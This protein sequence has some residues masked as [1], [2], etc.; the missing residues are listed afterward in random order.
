MR[1]PPKPVGAR[2]A[3]RCCVP[4][5]VFL[6][7][8]RIWSSA[9]GFLRDGFAAAWAVGLSRHDGGRRMRRPPSCLDKPTAHAAA[10][11]SLRK[12]SAEDQILARRRNTQAGTQHLTAGRAPTGLGG[13]RMRR[14]YSV[15]VSKP[16]LARNH[17]TTPS[18]QCRGQLTSHMS[19]PLRT[20]PVRVPPAHRPHARPRDARG[21]EAQLEQQSFP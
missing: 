11:P 1:R 5:C 10:K 7:R 21:V 4:A 17:P 18:V 6:R 12:P 9:L 19:G 16:H 20:R 13:R 14:P 2:P 8:A 15:I 3:V